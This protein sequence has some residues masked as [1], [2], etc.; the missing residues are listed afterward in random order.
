MRILLIIYNSKDK[1]NLIMLCL[2]NFVHN[3]L[4]KKGSKTENIRIYIL[5][6]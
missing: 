4:W 1:V 3:T 2:I 6:F 5:T